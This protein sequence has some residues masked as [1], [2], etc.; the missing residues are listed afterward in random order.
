MRRAIVDVDQLL[1]RE[2][3]Q[4]EADA[5]FRVGAVVDSVVRIVVAA[6]AGLRQD[7]V[8][9][10]ID[11]QKIVSGAMLLD[12]IASSPI[13][14]SVQVKVLRDGKEQTIPVMIADRAR[15]IDGEN[16]PT[17][18]AALSAPALPTDRVLGINVQAVP[19]NYVKKYSL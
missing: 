11:G 16:P 7:D 13:D 18:N 19:Q 12:I 2:G 15:I 3:W 5:A 14:R 9:T 8:I 6:Q 10:Q 4:V 17:E 1:S